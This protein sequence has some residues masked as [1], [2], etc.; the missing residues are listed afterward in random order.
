MDRRAALD[1]LYAL[2]DRAATRRGGPRRLGDCTARDGWPSH[3]VYFFFEPGEDREDGRTPRVVRVGTHALTE[4]SRTKLWGRLRTHR[5]RVGG[6]HPG[7]GNHRGSIFR[8]HVGTALLARDNAFPEAAAT[9]GHGSSAPRE[10]RDREV[11]LEQ[12][13][14]RHIGDMHVVVLDVPDRH[15]RAAIERGCIAL[16]SN[17]DRPAVDPPSPHWLGHQTDRHAIRSSG[18]WN[19]NH[20][21]EPPDAGVLDLVASPLTWET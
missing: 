7:G 5:G 18:L 3:G 19:V 11:A 4:T 17:H 10:V 13:V 16:L 1:E 20:V 2:L 21:T 14:S 15:D 12:A 6:R 8:L 9:W